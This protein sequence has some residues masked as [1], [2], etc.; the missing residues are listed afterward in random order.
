VLDDCV[1][2]PVV[3]CAGRVEGELRGAFA[4]TVRARILFLSPPTAIVTIRPSRWRWLLGASAEEYEA[5]GV[6]SVGG[7]YSWLRRSPHGRDVLVS[8]Q[9]AEVLERSLLAKIAEMAVACARGRR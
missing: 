8:C 1:H 9:V 4:V 3:S 2:D 6:P 5:W 7:T